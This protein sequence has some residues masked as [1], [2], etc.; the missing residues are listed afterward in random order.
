MDDEGLHWGAELG[1]LAP[2]LI[3]GHS[4]IYLSR[5]HRC[6]SCVS[7]SG[8]IFIVDSSKNGTKTSVV[9]PKNRDV[10]GCRFAGW[11]GFFVR[12]SVCM[13]VCVC[14]STS[15]PLSRFPPATC[16]FRLLAFPSFPYKR[17]SLPQSQRV[18]VYCRTRLFVILHP[19][20]P[21]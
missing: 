15:F 8:Y 14:R 12:G 5:L 1:T 4:A 9:L 17:R 13:F 20:S 18:S 2:S 16:A 19:A 3:Q 10:L 6:D 7:F 21:S 11:S